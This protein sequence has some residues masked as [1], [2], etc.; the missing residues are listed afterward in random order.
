MARQLANPTSIHED[1]GSIRGLRIRHCRELRCRLQTWL[2]ARVAVALV[3]AGGY[4]SDLTLS[5][6]TSIC[7]GSGPRKGK[8]TTKP[9]K[10]FRLLQR[11]ML[12][13]YTWEL[14]WSLLPM[15]LGRS[16][17]LVSNF[18]STFLHRGM[19]IYPL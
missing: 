13:M 4:S 9:N 10:A 1:M 18:D 11:Q 6:G 17:W 7:H 3:Q 16:Y 5:R 14:M 8:K 15:P 2:G 19:C 12:P